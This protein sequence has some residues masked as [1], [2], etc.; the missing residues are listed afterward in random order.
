LYSAPL[1]KFIKKELK[2]YKEIIKTGGR[3]TDSFQFLTPASIRIFCLGGL[4][5]LIKIIDWPSNFSRY[6]IAHEVT[7][8]NKLRRLFVAAHAEKTRARVIMRFQMR[9][10]D[11]CLISQKKS[12]ELLN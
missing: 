3:A 4:C 1:E 6:R 9:R 5:R 8:A 12:S 2:E 11:A 10:L 7:S